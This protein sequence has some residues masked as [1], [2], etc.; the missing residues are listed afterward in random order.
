MDWDAVVRGPALLPT[1][2]KVGAETPLD[3]GVGVRGDGGPA[4]LYRRNKDNGDSA[5]A[6]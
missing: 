3:E 5:S 4:R 6:Y 1:D 2:D